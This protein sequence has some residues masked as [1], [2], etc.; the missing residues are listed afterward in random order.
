MDHVGIRQKAQP[1]LLEEWF[2][3]C[4][5]QHQLCMCL[6]LAAILPSSSSS[7]EEK[8]STP[9]SNRKIAVRHH[10]L[11]CRLSSWI[12]LTLSYFFFTGHL[13]RR[14]CRRNPSSSQTRTNNSCTGKQIVKINSRTGSLSWLC[15]FLVVVFVAWVHLWPSFCCDSSFR[16]ST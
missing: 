2:F 11:P 13:R 14:P 6:L 15:L 3:I 9:N 4:V 16:P 5:V 1:H 12:I 7:K 10:K 8:E